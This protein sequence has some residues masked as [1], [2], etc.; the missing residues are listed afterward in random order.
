M[1]P[2]V[3]SLTGDTTEPLPASVVSTGR[4][5]IPVTPFTIPFLEF[6]PGTQPMLDCMITITN[7]F[8]IFDSVI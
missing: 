7:D 5:E 8:Q 6:G 4:I 1:S 2:L 3:F